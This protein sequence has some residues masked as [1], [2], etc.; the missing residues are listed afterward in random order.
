MNTFTKVLSALLA[1]IIFNSCASSYNMILPENLWYQS[2]GITGEVDFSYKYDV[3]NEKGNKKYAKKESAKFVKVV[4]VKVVNRSDQSFVF[5]TDMK[6]HSNDHAISILEP[7][8][9]HKQ[10]K[11]STPIYLLYLLLT[12]A[13]LYTEDSSI[14]IGLALGPGIASGNMGMAAGAN[15]NF[16]KELESNFLNGRTIEAGETV[17]GLIGILES[18]YN[19]L[20]LK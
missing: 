20:S 6:V 7:H 9:I 4:A 15:G 3:L 2:T 5:G 11:Q 13:R 18:G 1:G 12:P 17:F 14:P 10:L 8:E 19:P 16:K